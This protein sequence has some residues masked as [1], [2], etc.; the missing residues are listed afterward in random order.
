MNKTD[1]FSLSFT[2]DQS[3]CVSSISNT[4]KFKVFLCVIVVRMHLDLKELNSI[5][6]FPFENFTHLKGK[7]LAIFTHVQCFMQGKN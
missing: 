7:I 6:R 1:V 4:D 5:I 3:K 2:S